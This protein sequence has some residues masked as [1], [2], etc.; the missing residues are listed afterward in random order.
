MSIRIYRTA[1]AGIVLGMAAL[2]GVHAALGASETNSASASTAAKSLPVAEIYEKRCKGCHA[3]IGPAIQLKWSSANPADLATY[4][5]KSMPPGAA[6]PL[7]EATAAQLATH[8]LELGRA[9]QS[10][11]SE[12]DDDIS[13][14]AKARLR[15]AADRLTPVTDALLRDPPKEDWL[16]WRGD[17]GASGFSPLTQIDPTNVGQLRLVWSRTLGPGTNGIAPLAHDGVLF[18]YGGGR[19]SAFDGQSGDTIWSRAAPS[20]RRDLTQPRGV[21]LYGTALYASTSENHVLALDARTGALHWD[22]KITGPGKF[23]FTAAPLVANGRVF[24]GASQ[25]ASRGSRCFMLALDAASGEELWR[26]HTIP[27][28]GEPGAES[29]GGAPVE[30]RSGAGIW[31]GSSFDYDRDQIVFGTGNTYAVTTL[32]KPGAGRIAA[33]LYT[34][35]T[36]KLDARTGKVTWFY[37]HFPGDVWDEDAA[38]ERTFIQDPRGERRRAVINIGKLGILDALDLGTGSYL[39]SIDLGFQNLIT[40]IDPKTGAKTVDRSAIPGTGKPT[41][42]C[43]YAGGVRN[44]PATSYDPDRSLLFVAVLDAC[45]TLSID[46]SK[47]QESAWT[48]QPRAGSDH[49]YGGLIAV[50]LRSGKPLW[51]TRHRAPPASAVLATKSGVV[52]EGTRDRWFRARDTQTGKVL[53][54]VRLTDT[55]NSFPITFMAD[56]RQY[57]AVVTGGGTYVDGL[58]GHLTPEI[59]PSTGSMSLWVFALDNGTERP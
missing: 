54:R 32:L 24:Q 41:T 58:I 25:C 11:V 46:A 31:S 9:S 19:I 42:I 3:N 12:F 18:L 23:T 50:D 40:R 55:P 8:L 1:I 13:R 26:T 27:A 43:P 53:W 14:A 16:V 4:L 15:E 2:A 6:T 29:W 45:M 57:V 56:G 28:T 39:W 38:F 44:W 30:E 59:E 52:F 10:A 48:V 36:L 49:Q 37:Q 20:G 7:D 5:R 33:G 22:R 35:T 47:D 34:N 17:V 51:N 21:A